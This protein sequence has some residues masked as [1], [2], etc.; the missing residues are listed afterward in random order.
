VII[1]SCYAAVLALLFVGLSIHTIR[2]RRC[3]RIALGDQ[4]DLEL[5]RAIR[6]QGNCAEY[7]PFTLVLMICL[8]WQGASSLYLHVAGLCL[9]TG[10]F[11]HAWAIYTRDGRLRVIG[12]A[13]TFTAL[14]GS[15]LRLLAHPLIS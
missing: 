7:V 11:C 3:K 12:M 14:I 5:Q 9:L 4:G 10:R 2:L 8:E 13:L 6:M 1:T 15:A